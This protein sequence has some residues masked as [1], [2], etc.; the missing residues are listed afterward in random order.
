MFATESLLKEGF[1]NNNWLK[2]EVK[3]DMEKIPE[4]TLPRVM[5]FLN[6]M[7]L[8]MAFRE[9]Y[10][11]ETFE[12]L[13]SFMEK[14]GEK[15]GQELKQKQG[16]IGKS[17]ED[18]KRMFEA[19]TAPAYESPEAGPKITIEG[20]KMIVERS[21]ETKCPFIYVSQATGLPLKQV[22]ELIAKPTVIGAFKTV[23]STIQHSF[24][25]VTEEYCKEIYE[26][27]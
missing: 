20:N 3:K 27:K 10:G 4:D 1:I 18:I 21:K 2:N 16:I 14:L 25:E 9:K 17:I 6:L 8:T 19:T 12:T 7:R 22:C 26:I 11:D 5:P 24:S 23:N 15:R 13:R